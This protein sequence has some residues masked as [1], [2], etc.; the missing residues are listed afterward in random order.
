MKKFL[1]QILASFIGNLAGLFFFFALSGAGLLIFFFALLLSGNTPKIENQSA[2][3]FNLNTQISDSQSESN[4]SSLISS[5]NTQT[6]T[7]REITLAINTAAKDNR[8]T[9]LFLDGSQGNITTGYASLTE[10]R[11]A[12]EN[13]KASGKKII[14]YNVSTGETDYF[15]TSI[16]DEINLNPIGGMEMNGFASSQLFFASGLEKYGIGSQI[17]R[18]GKYKSAVEPFTRNDF[19]PESEIQTSELLDDLWDSYLEV[20]TKN[21]PLK[22]GEINNI[23]DNKGILQPEEAKD[24]KLVDQLIYED[25]IIDRLKTITNSKDEDTFHQVTIRDY[26]TANTSSDT[27]QNNKI[28]ILYVEGSIVDGEGRIREV[29]SNRFVNEIRKIRQDKNIKGVVVRINSPG[30]SAVASELILRELQLTASEKPLVISMGDVAAS[31]GY[32]IATAGERIFASNNTIT[33]SIGVFGLLFNIE[34]IANQNGISNDVIKTNQFADLGNTFKPKTEPELA[35]FQQG[36]EKIYELFLERVS[37]SR[38]L[39]V[40]K[41]VDIA[42]GRVWSGKSAQKIGLVDE[43]GGLDA[44]IQY[45]NEK[46]QLN[47]NY[48]IVSYP[49]SRTWEIEL[50]NRLNNTKLANNLTDKEILTKI[51][52]ELN[53]ELNLKD[54]LQNPHQ[55]YSILP[56]KLNI[57]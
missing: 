24:L 10:I 46:L 7:L 33:G 11:T 56:Y 8:I 39:P 20:I 6:L 42:Q 30:G 23:A 17:I 12:L 44:S 18:V 50:I 25:Q 2:L 43:I 53:T 47:D 45:L 22:T 40:S 57:K 1:Q 14:A 37:L 54:I 35:I 36:V 51:I 41:V 27:P 9:T 31:G 52:W 38:N 55:V 19:S 16:A 5:N 32:W 49:E 26:L 48:D 13:F 15:L 28:A 3:V 4:L 34:N 29:G 21:R